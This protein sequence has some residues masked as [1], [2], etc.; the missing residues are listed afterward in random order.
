MR[1][2]LWILV[3]VVL[4]GY[5]GFLVGEQKLKL[6]IRNWKVGVTSREMPKNLAADFGLFWMVW[7]KLSEQYVDKSALDPQK[8]VDGAISGMVQSV[9]DP[10]TVYLPQ[11]PADKA[12]VRAGDLILRIKDPAKNVDRDTERMTLPEAVGLIRGQKGTEVVLTLAREGME[13]P[14]EVSLTRDTIVVKS[15]TVEFRDG[16]AILKLNRFGDRTQNEWNEAVSQIVTKGARG[17]VLDLRNNP[18]GYLDGAVYIAGE[19][20]P[21]GREVVVQQYGDGIKE[22][23]RVDRN[24]RL[25]KTKLVVVINEGSASAA[26]ILAGALQDYKRVRVVGMKSFGKGSVQQPEDFPGGAGLHVTIAKWLRPSGEWIDK[27]GI[28]PDVEVKMDDKDESNDLQ[29][30]KALEML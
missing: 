5:G 24:G 12:G 26:E 7:D 15:A 2:N 16:V 20:L 17:M 28:K 25:L 9:G 22:S 3:V 18:G 30:K 11:T 1:K 29:L 23:R 14:F 6:E 19:F 4:A 8:M 13:K 27:V 21:A 10:Y